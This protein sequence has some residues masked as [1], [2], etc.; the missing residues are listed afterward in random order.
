M[1]SL[2]TQTSP[3]QKAETGNTLKFHNEIATDE[4]SILTVSPVYI[5]TQSPSFP[6]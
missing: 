3:K 1:E 6:K 5:P 2:L 4:I